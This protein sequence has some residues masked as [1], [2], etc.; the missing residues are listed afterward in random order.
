MLVHKSE[1]CETSDGY[2]GI[3]STA[4]SC[5][6]LATSFLDLCGLLCALWFCIE[7]PHLCGFVVPQFLSL[8]GI[9]RRGDMSLIAQTGVGYGLKVAI[10]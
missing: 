8:K 4:S 5:W 6:L 10:V 9:G 1:N 2:W 7:V 3:L